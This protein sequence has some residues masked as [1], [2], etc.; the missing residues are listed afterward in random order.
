MRLHEFLFGTA[1]MSIALVTTIAAAPSL[2]C[3]NCRP[4][5][6]GD[7]R[8]VVGARTSEPLAPPLISRDKVLG[9]AY[10][11]TV[12]ILRSNN[13]CSD[14]FGG[15]PSIGIFNALVSK[16][17]KD[18]LSG[19]VGMRM[20]GA[21]MHIHDE[22]TKKNYRLFEKVSLNSRGPFYRRKA[23][24]W[25]ATVPRIGTFQPNTREARVL[26]LL[27]ELGHLVKGSDGQWLLPDDGNDDGLSR[28]NSQKIEDVCNEQLH[29]LGRLAP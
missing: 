15:P 23:G 13:P 5:F 19:D 14:F 20:S 4:D 9:S 7:V 1:L 17:R 26:L 12:S 10:Y 22:R 27:H 28:A 16:I 8:S 11:D 3:D 6:A 18:T 2:L 29:S 25:E 21:T 24:L